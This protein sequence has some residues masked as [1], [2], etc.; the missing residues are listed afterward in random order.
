MLLDYQR[1]GPTR[2]VVPV[3]RKQATT[4]PSRPAKRSRPSKRA[5]AAEEAA[6]NAPRLQIHDGR[7]FVDLKRMLVE[8][9][10]TTGSRGGCS[11]YLK[12]ATTL[13]VLLIQYNSMR[14][15][16]DVGPVLGTS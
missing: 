16:V 11:L 4:T 1:S 9:C 12:R 10:G 5:L 6:K 2:L 13:L 7:K 15:A 3:V 8:V 14:A